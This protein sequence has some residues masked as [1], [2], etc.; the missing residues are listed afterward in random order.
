MTETR[1]LSPQDEDW[2]RFSSLS[3]M[4]NH[5]E[6][7]RWTAGRE[8]YYWYLCLDSPKL[9]EVTEYCQRR[10]PHRFLDPVPLDALHLTLP[11]LGWV[12]QISRD[13]LSAIADV[14][15]SSCASL[16]PFNMT[17]GPI[18]GSPGAVRFSVDPWRTVVALREQ[19]LAAVE[20]VRGAQRDQ[21]FRPHVGIAYCNDE[22]EAE[23]LI[24][25]VA[26][27]REL[28]TV[29]IGVS[30]VELVR[31]RREGRTYRWSVVETVSLGFSR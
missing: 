3:I 12:D 22:V 18:S 2:R 19:L 25:A 26:P 28:P 7:P 21:E 6:N 13:D 16:Q 31:L 8:A 30:K 15:R 5:W 24:E 17:I 29:E 1:E 9:R 10:L 11:K 23:P 4:K 20:S 27:L 14:A